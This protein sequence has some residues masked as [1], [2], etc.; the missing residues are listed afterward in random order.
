MG[1]LSLERKNNYL[2]YFILFYFI[3]YIYRMPKTRGKKKTEYEKQLE[4]TRKAV[5]KVKDA[6]YK[7]QLE[8]TRKAV[9]KV[10]DAKYKTQLEKT[11]KAVQKVK[12]TKLALKTKKPFKKAKTKLKIIPNNNKIKS[13]YAVNFKYNPKTR[14][15]LVSKQAKKGKCIFPFKN[16][17][18]T[19]PNQFGC[20]KSKKGD[21]SWCATKVKHN[22]LKE[23][24]GYCVPEGMTEDEYNRMYEN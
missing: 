5:Q 7:S 22:L 16:K 15:R 11:R 23:E 8:K 20:I 12:D 17:K 19:D 6:K 14:K 1:E 24:W 21:S 18:H 13:R 2:F 3:L 4:K 9:Q 10:K